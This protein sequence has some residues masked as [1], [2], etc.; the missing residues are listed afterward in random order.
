LPAPSARDAADTHPETRPTLRKQLGR[1]IALREP[2]GWCLRNPLEGQPVALD[3]AGM[4][5]SEAY[6]A[7]ERRAVALAPRAP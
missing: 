1:V 2:I 6:V 5:S 7:F 4:V 3:D